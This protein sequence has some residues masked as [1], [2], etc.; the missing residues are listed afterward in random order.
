MKIY[1]NAKYFTIK[2]KDLFIETWV[3]F[4]WFNQ[5][6]SLQAI[7]SSYVFVNNKFQIK[8]ELGFL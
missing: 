4:N 3:R 7:I 6:E 1:Q 2:Y 8:L 5:V